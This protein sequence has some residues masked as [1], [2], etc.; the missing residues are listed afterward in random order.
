MTSETKLFN[1]KLYLTNIKRMWP[2]WT[3]AAIGCIM[4]AIS[5]WVN[6]AD[7][8]NYSDSEL[9]VHVARSLLYDTMVSVTPILALI[10]S[11]VIGI[12][13]W[14]YLCYKSGVDF[15]H[16]IPLG[17]K[18][19]FFTNLLSAYTMVVI[20]FI[21]AIII[22]SVASAGFGV[23]IGTAIFKVLFL[24]LSEGL[25]FTT[26]YAFAAVLGGTSAS[27][28]ILYFVVNFIA[29]SFVD[30]INVFECGFLYGVN[31]KEVPA[32]VT[33]FSPVVFMLSKI[34]DTRQY[35]EVMID[36]NLEGLGWAALYAALS[37]VLAV[38]T[39]F[40]YAKRRSET[41]GD[42]VSFKLIKNI[43]LYVC[44]TLAAVGFAIVLYSV[45]DSSSDYYT[46]LMIFCIIVGTIICFFVAL[47]VVNGTIKVFSGKNIRNCVIL[48]AVMVIATVILS[49]DPAGEAK[50]V[51]EV[52]DI[53][54]LTFN[55]DGNETTL[56]SE[57]IEV[58]ETVRQLHLDI[59]SEGARKR[60]EWA[61]EDT[62]Y[63]R[64]DYSLNSGEKLQRLYY[65]PVTRE[66]LKDADSLENKLITFKNDRSMYG[67]KLHVGQNNIAYTYAYI[68]GWDAKTNR[69]LGA[70]LS[71]DLLSDLR[72]AIELDYMEGHIPTDSI[73][74]DDYEDKSTLNIEIQ[75]EDYLHKYEKE[76]LD[77][78]EYAFE[79]Y[80]ARINIEY[81]GEMKNL[82]KFL[83]DN[84]IVDENVL[85]D[86]Q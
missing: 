8:Y 54:S 21:P 42:F 66:N 60:K 29:A 43:L 74:Y 72:K 52:N 22:Y 24:V 68:W 20:P 85:A 34:T 36:S 23:F 79:E 48:S 61:G 46:G 44:A 27:Q 75:I 65:I 11:A 38:V 80:D 62:V 49:M 35:A 15:M 64:F 81:D 53:K 12:G 5:G 57:D 16:A 76:E 18:C 26:L 25:V 4:S 59:V 3:L 73:F 2:L 39:Y 6:L 67:Y 83:L 82:T 19:I 41:A 55:F 51:P 47:M 30:V 50:K 7:R 40:V 31:G 33:F 70:D 13:I 56:W 32:F 10:L 86:I 78:Y 17:R 71:P 84:N 69:D 9:N 58:L 37:I 1:K 28:M 45:F 77:R 63:V 14:S